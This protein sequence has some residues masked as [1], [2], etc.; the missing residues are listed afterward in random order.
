M[1]NKT[2]KSIAD[3]A[4]FLGT[5]IVLQTVATLIMNLIFGTATGSYTPTVVASLLSAAA[6]VA[7]FAWRRWTPMSRHYINTRPWGVLFWTAMAAMGMSGLS[8]WMQDVLHL[9]MP[10]QLTQLFVGIMNHPLGYIVVGLLAPVAEE[11]VFRGALLR[12]LLQATEGRNHW[13]AIAISAMWFGIVHGNMAQGCNAFVMGLLL[14]WLYSRTRSITPGI[15][16]HWMNNTMAYVMF[17][18]MPG[19]ADMSLTELFQGD[20]R[21]VAIYVACSLCVLLPSLYQLRSRAK[22]A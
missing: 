6:T 19:A 15:V 4:I 7:L 2:V 13:W 20:T 17:R 9:D 10:E 16:L 21:K 22:Q 18:L 12:S 3:T 8:A 11:V 14:G 1:M 5:Y